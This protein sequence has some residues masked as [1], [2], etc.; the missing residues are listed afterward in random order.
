MLEQVLGITGVLTAILTVAL[1][2]LAALEAVSLLCPPTRA[3]PGQRSMMRLSA[4]VIGGGSPRAPME[5][6]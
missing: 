6:S 3:R 2:S 4:L 5:P 1:S